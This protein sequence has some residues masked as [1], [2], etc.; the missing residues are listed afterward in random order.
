MVC[1]ICFRIK[2]LYYFQGSEGKDH[3]LNELTFDILEVEIVRLQQL[4][5][6]VQEGWFL[7]F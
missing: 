1:S 6:D 3:N 2:C 7:P 4:P 5:H